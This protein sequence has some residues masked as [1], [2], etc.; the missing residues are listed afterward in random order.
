MVR[1]YITKDHTSFERSIQF[2]SDED[3]YIKFEMFST[4]PKFTQKY[5]V[6]D[7]SLV[8]KN[9]KRVSWRSAS[10]Y[11]S[12]D[13]INP[14]E[15]TLNY[16][17]AETGLY[18]VD[19][20]YEQNSN[21]YSDNTFNTHKDLMGWCDIYSAGIKDEHISTIVS[22]SKV[23][24]PINDALIGKIDKNTRALLEKAI[25]AKV[26]EAL[27]PSEAYIDD[28]IEPLETEFVQGIVRDLVFDGED[29]VLKTK[30]VF[31]QLTAG[32][33]NINFGVPHNCYVIGAI[34]RKVDR[35]WG[36]NND[37]AGSNLQFKEAKLTISDMTKSSSLEVTVGYDNSFEADTRSGLF[38]NFMDECNLYVKNH[39]G[40]IERVFGGYVSTPLPD[41]KGLEIK[42][43]CADRLRDG[44]NRYILNELQLDGG[45]SEVTDYS[46][47][48]IISF[49]SYPQILKY[50]CELYQTTLKNSISANFQVEGEKFIEGK[51]ITYGK[52]K[53]IK[54]IPVNNGTVEINRNSVTLRNNASSKNKQVW[55]LYDAKKHGKAPVNLAQYDNEDEPLNLHIVYGIGDVKT[56][57]KSKETITTDVSDS[58]AGSQKFGKCGVSQDKK[59]LMAIGLPSAGKDSVKGWTKTIFERKCPCCGSTELVWDWNWGSY[60]SCRGAKEGGTAEGHI[61]C[62]SCDADW[63][64]QGYSHENRSGYCK[65]S[66]KKSSTTVSSSKKEAQKLKNGEMTGVP[67]STAPIQPKEVFKAIKN[68]CKGWTHQ[69]GTGSTASYLEKHGVGD[70]WAWS[71]WIS[72]QLKKY[73]VNHKIVEYATGSSNNHRSVLYLDANHKWQDFPYSTY[74]FPKGTHATA[75]SKNG[76]LIYKYSNGGTIA[77]VTSTG[78]SS[79]SQTQEV[80]TTYGY[81]KD[82]PFQGYLDIV[83][84]LD[85]GFKSKKYHFYIDFTQSAQSNNSIHELSP[86]WIN[87]STKRATIKGI[88]QKIKSYNNYADYVGIYLQSIHMITPKVKSTAGDKNKDWYTF[89]K[90]TKDYSSCKMDL[91]QIAFNNF[92]GV[93]TGGL[94]T[95][96]KSVNEVISTIVSDADYL[97]YMEYGEHRCDDIVHFKLNKNNSAVFTAM[98]GNNNN[99]LE[100]GNINYNPANELFN[101]SVCVF[102]SKLDKKYH[103]VDT[104]DTDSI[105]EFG[106]QCTI[107]TLN[108]EIGEKQAYWNARHNEKYHPTQDYSFTITVKGYP[109]LKL[110]ELVEIL[111]N[112]KRLDT[113]KECESITMNYT[114]KE[115][116]VIQTELG[117][118]ELAPDIQ[119]KKT[120]KSLRDNVKERVPFNEGASAITTEDVYEWDV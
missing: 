69:T 97:M 75:K 106:E 73:K 14:V 79:K 47:E 23:S 100:W 85:K 64:V 5:K 37:E 38:F 55:T 80:T 74:G 111:A 88:V 120:I 95:C 102:K 92:Q 101:M 54:K 114:Y 90:T 15:F 108:D 34:I 20:L 77:Q 44:E 93:K 35:Y 9:G 53:A 45:D 28:L 118:G 60:S 107:E 19:I 119:L 117:L 70:C 71:D 26:E 48:N 72:K 109:S 65:K 36:T 12:A 91:Y 103:Y 56:T 42:I 52:K 68:A 4:D 25:N 86:V 50:L 58:T 24:N 49:T 61:F 104:R 31:R 89:D 3:E 76:K 18:R 22:D 84:S 46:K 16:N 30:T 40:N 33:Y 32:E 6:E 110:G 39:E 94:D 116:P 10:C 27:D 57:H 11:Q 112:S 29:D 21:M 7:G 99:I 83:Y 43:H 66:L 82:A 105:L 13:K 113:V 1:K 17:V 63:S 51:L 41:E 62:K 96:G 81:D 59:Y 2:L 8:C 87:N 67:K 78:S 115:K 98:E